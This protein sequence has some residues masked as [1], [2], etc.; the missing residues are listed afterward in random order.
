MI[1]NT[2]GEIVQIQVLF[3][4][5]VGLNLILPVNATTFNN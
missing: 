1:Q 5:T 3:M 2:V 4:T